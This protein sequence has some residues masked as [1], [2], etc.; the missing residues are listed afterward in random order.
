MVQ[1]R[2]A[3]RAELAEVAGTSAVTAGK[4]VDELLE[5]GVLEPAES[6][7]DGARPGRPGQ[8][9]RL[10]ARVPR[11]VLIQM[12]VAHTRVAFAPLGAEAAGLGLAGQAKSGD[13]SPWPIEIETPE[14]AADWER[15]VGRAIA[16]L[17]PRD[18]WGTLVSVPG[19]VDE[20]AGRV[21]YSPNL[22]WSEGMDFRRA[23]R[24][25]VDAPVELV[26]EIR[27]LALGHHA[28]APGE[29]DFLLVDFGHGVGGAAVL[30]GGL[31][32]GALPMAGEIGH[33]PVVDNP[34]PCGCGAKGC[35]ETLLSRRGLF[36]SMAE[37]AGDD[38]G[39]RGRYAWPAVQRHVA[40]NGIEPWLRRSLQAAGAN[41]AGAMNV[42]GLGRVVITGSLAD[43]GT[44]VC[45]VL[46]TEVR[47]AALWGRFGQLSIEFAP[48]RRMRGLISV[49]IDRLLVDAAAGE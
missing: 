46:E 4:I 43:L 42:L 3:A 23:L 21:L 7:R 10:N 13:E 2:S 37:A 20:E 22:H 11:F 49:G 47:K 34:R 28:A 44:A 25:S 6:R 32:Q 36:A 9:L 40:E 31:Y 18:A 5:Q 24:G 26:H 12:G 41:I 8:G 1:V 33:T 30:H 14:S 35:L 39:R 38:G 15:A 19:L 48:R 17:D 16:S 29:T 27:A 45:G